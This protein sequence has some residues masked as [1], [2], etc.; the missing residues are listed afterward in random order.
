MTL[1]TD[2]VSELAKRRILLQFVFSC[3]TARLFAWSVEYR[4][5]ELIDPLFNLQQSSTQVFIKV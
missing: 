1:K 4:R 2:D 3:N 5:A